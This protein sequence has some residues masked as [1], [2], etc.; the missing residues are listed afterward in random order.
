MTGGL[1]SLAV[2]ARD[3]HMNLTMQYVSRAQHF[4]AGDMFHKHR[5]PLHTE[6]LTL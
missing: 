4:M 2:C 1:H 5:L 6:G 3:C